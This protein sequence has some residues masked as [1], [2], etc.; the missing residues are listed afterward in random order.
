[1]RPKRCGH[2]GREDTLERVEDVLY[3]TMTFPVELGQG[4]I[5]EHEEQCRVLI[6]RCTW[7]RRPTF[8][9]YA[10]MDGLTSD[11]EPRGWET[12]YPE[13]RPLL[14]LAER[15]R[16]RYREMLELLD[17]PDAFAMRAGKVLESIC[18]EQGH[19][20]GDLAPRMKK[21]IEDGHLPAAL[22][23]Q[24]DLVRKYRNI[25]SHDDARLDVEERDV[26]LIRDF[27]ES[28][29][30]YLYWGP[31]KLRRGE[32]AL[33]QRKSGKPTLGLF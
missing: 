32:E 22:G 3:E 9:S 27:V 5:D 1:M 12:H 26:P 18:N 4:F 20:K 8:S 14:D 19:S 28:L 15:V 23:A 6:L 31:A 17:H 25:G 13:E 7:C 29:L 33:E 30:D 11:D 16:R 2:C 10:W 21:L 24:A